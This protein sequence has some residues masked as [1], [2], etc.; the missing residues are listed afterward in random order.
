MMA[1]NPAIAPRWGNRRRD[2]KAEAILG[3]LQAVEG[4]LKLQTRWLDIGCGSGGI[5][6]ALSRHVE[7]VVGLDPEPWAGWNELEHVH[8]NLKFVV[9][10]GD[11]ETLP[12]PGASFD[13]I[14]CNQVYEH[15]RQPA[16]LIEN[17]QRLLRPGG[18]CYFAGPNLLWPIE[19]HVYLPVVHWL[20]R[21]STVSLLKSVGFRHVDRLDAFSVSYWRLAGWFQDN[22]LEWQTAIVDR[23]A[24]GLRNGGHQVIAAAVSALPRA[25]EGLLHPL[26]PGFVFV[27]KKPH[28]TASALAQRGMPE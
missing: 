2:S 16:R 15:V 21:R 3:T 28:N 13:V 22:G 23:L 9:G 1:S 10:H 8:P 12:L 25:V 24:A 26:A 18:I 11:R 17:I 7:E 6:A 14:V 19:P 27:L 4:S 20:P 5:A